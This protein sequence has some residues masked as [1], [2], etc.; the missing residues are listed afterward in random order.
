[1][2]KDMIEY[3]ERKYSYNFVISTF[4]IGCLCSTVQ[5]YMYAIEPL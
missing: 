1:M 5:M 3:N 4:R 2:D